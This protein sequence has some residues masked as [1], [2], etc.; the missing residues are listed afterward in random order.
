MYGEV[1][2]EVHRLGSDWAAT[3][4]VPDLL[5]GLELRVSSRMTSSGG[6]CHL[7]LGRIT[8]ARWVVDA[9]HLEVVAC[10]ELA[11]LAAFR[12]HGRVRAHGREWRALMVAAGHEPRARH[13]WETPPRSPRRTYTYSVACTTCGGH[14]TMR[15]WKSTYRCARCVRA[16]CSGLFSVVRIPSDA[17]DRWSIAS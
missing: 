16:G 6:K 10:H 7:L 9:G 1:E 17:P 4:G 3:W 2:A 5:D 12:L 14:W 13:S 11:H 15:A 8:V